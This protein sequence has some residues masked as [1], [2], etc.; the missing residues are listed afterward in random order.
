MGRGKTKRGRKAKK[1]KGKERGMQNLQETFFFHFFPPMAV[2]SLF[3]FLVSLLFI[4][5]VLFV[6]Y[7][8]VSFFFF[9]FA[10]GLCVFR[11]KRTKLDKGINNNNK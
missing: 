6:S 2:S 10:G 4:R 7:A 3:F 9:F 1:Q 5:V 11:S 8:F